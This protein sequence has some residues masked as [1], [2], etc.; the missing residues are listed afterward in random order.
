MNFIHHESLTDASTAESSTPT[1]ILRFTRAKESGDATLVFSDLICGR[2]LFTRS[3]RLRTREH[4]LCWGPVPLWTAY[5]S[6]VASLITLTNLIILVNALSSTPSP[7]PPP[8]FSHSLSP[9][10]TF[11]RPT[12]FIFISLILLL[13]LSLLLLLHPP[14]P[15]TSPPLSFPL[16]F[17][18]G[19]ARMT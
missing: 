10:G 14:P 4:E 9:I 11:S 18:S 3:R 15:P 12:L 5:R 17:L 6:H 19:A 13:L 16:P 8:P 2:R 7:L 1:R